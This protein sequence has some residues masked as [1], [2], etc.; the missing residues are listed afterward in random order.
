MRRACQQL[1]HA[2]ALDSAPGRGSRFRVRLPLMRDVCLMPDAPRA[3]GRPTAFVAGRRVLIV[4]NDPAMR[5]A[6]GMLLRGW[7][8]E[9]ADAGGV[10]EARA[11]VR[12]GTV[13]DVVLTDYRLDDDE[14]GMQTIEA[15][16]RRP[17]RAAAGADRQRR[18]RRGDPAARRPARRAG[19]REAGRRERAP[20]GARDAAGGARVSDV[21]RACAR[22]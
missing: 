12:E 18:G 11:A 6:F 16:R 13:P 8:M 4:E 5:Q 3:A 15:L 14:T 2:V 7:G 17:R 9:V 1:G 19:A 10:A 21:G 20:A 22:G